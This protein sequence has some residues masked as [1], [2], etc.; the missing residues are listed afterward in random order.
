MA[1]VVGR[2]VFKK[3]DPG[4]LRAIIE[5]VEAHSALV[6]AQEEHA[7]TDNLGSYEMLALAE[8]RWQ[9]LRKRADLEG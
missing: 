7:K 3:P 4:T 9:A 6:E 5:V 2:K 1:S 8:E